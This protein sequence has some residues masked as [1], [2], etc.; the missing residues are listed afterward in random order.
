[1]GGKGRMGGMD[2]M[3]GMGGMGG[4]SGMGRA[5][6]WAEKSEWVEFPRS[7]I[8]MEVFAGNSSRIWEANQSGN[9]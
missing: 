6:F 7:W 2:G 5:E 3:G 8:F 9:F 1:M 4:M